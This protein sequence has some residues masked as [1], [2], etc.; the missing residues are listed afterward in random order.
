MVL[1]SVVFILSPTDKVDKPSSLCQAPQGPSLQYSQG[2]Q[3]QPI[4]TPLPP[5]IVTYPLLPPCGVLCLHRPGENALR[6]SSSTEKESCFHLSPLLLALKGTNVCSPS[7]RG[8]S[9]RVRWK[10]LCAPETSRCEAVQREGNR[11]ARL[12][13]STM[14]SSCFICTCFPGPIYDDQ[15]TLLTRKCSRAYPTVFLST[16][17][18][19]ERGASAHAAEAIVSDA[20]RVNHVHQLGPAL[21][22]C[23]TN[24]SFRQQINQLL[25]TKYGNSTCA[26][27]RTLER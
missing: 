27:C 14:C 10:L 16:V 7:P 2:K 1:I 26:L 23:V 17:P 22:C 13:A 19:S 6:F 18:H 9:V 25:E 8:Q 5:P 21:I 15:N 20:T 11:C 4:P 3:H 24:W 12:L